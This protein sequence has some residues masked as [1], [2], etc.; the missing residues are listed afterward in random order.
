MIKSNYQLFSIIISIVLGFL[1]VKLIKNNLIKRIID[2]FIYTIYIIILVVTIQNIVF[3]DNRILNLYIYKI[4]S[5]SME[6]TLYTNDYI[7]VKKVNI[8]KAGDI[9]TYQLDNKTIT[10]RIIRINNDQIITKGDANFNI[11]KGISKKQI[12]GKVIAHGSLVNFLISYGSYIIVVYSTTYIVVDIIIKSKK[13][14]K[15]LNLSI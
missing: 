6:N 11:D 4:S 12:I 14:S 2:I 15:K 3:K 9:I 8:Y 7:V 10:H 1:T 5:G 13:T